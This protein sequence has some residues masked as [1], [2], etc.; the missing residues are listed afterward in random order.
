MLDAI[1]AR[2]RVLGEMLRRR[3]IDRLAARPVS[4][5]VRIEESDEGVVLTGKR[6]K[7]RFV[8]DARVRDLLR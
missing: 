6:L 1:A 5:G 8:T 7:R 2:G 4:P 3:A